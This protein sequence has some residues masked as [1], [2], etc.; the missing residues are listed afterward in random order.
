MVMKEPEM[1]ARRCVM[2]K[3]LDVYSDVKLCS[4]LCEQFLILEN[5]FKEI[6]KRFPAGDGFVNDRNDIPI[7]RCW[8]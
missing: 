4:I 3:M 5:E 7:S 2:M 6:L 8:V 1:T